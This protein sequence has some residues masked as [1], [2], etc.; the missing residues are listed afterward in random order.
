MEHNL[1]GCSMQLRKIFPS[2]GDGARGSMHAECEDGLRL[3]RA[4]RPS[5][6]A[7][8]SACGRIQPFLGC[9]NRGRS[10]RAALGTAKETRGGR[11]AREKLPGIAGA[12]SSGCDHTGTKFEV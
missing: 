8:S 2:S 3:R 1:I 10:F 6:S 11:M 9:R 12:T 7:S 4:L 5:F